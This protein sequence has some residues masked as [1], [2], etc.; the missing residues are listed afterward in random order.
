MFATN[1]ERGP[2]VSARWLGYIRA[3]S[4]LLI[5]LASSATAYPQSPAN[6]IQASIAPPGGAVQQ[7]QTPVKIIEMNDEMPM[8]QPDSIVIVAGQTVEWHNNGQVSHSVVDDATRAAKPEDALI[9]RGVPTFS[10]GNVMPGGTY[11][12]TFTVPGRYRYFCMSHEL[13]DMVGQVLVLPST[14]GNT[15]AAIAEAKAEAAPPPKPAMP[16]N[17]VEASVA[18]PGAT[19]EGQSP[20]VKIIEMNDDKPMYEPSNIVIVAGQT[21]EWHNNGEVSHSIVD[22]ATRAAKPEDALIPRGERTFN[23]GGIMPGGTYKHTFTVPGRYRYFCMSHEL[24]DMVGE[25]TVLPPSGSAEP[26]L[27]QAKSQP[28]KR[29]ERDSDGPI[30]DP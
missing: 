12:H 25:I 6:S 20:P 5:V 10:S 13:D 15:A 1:S 16:P 17:P 3:I 18:P 29:L 30:P 27:S 14:P 11:K 24:D 23:S 28:W 9:P 7:P 22:D 2:G 19:V 21:V 26:L 4:A 8:Y